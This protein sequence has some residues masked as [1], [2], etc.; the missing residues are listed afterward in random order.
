[1]LQYSLSLFSFKEIIQNSGADLS[2]NS[3]KLS[4]I[5][6]DSQGGLQF[7]LIVFGQHDWIVTSPFQFKTT[8]VIR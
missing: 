3:K 1:V 8:P 5:A 7:F 6:T 4:P 2:K